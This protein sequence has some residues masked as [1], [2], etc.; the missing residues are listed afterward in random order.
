MSELVGN[1]VK[2]ADGRT[3]L[4]TVRPAE[5]GARV[6]VTDVGAACPP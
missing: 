1:A 3:L 2:C 6:V 4:I 5:R